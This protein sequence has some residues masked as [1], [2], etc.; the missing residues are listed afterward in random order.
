MPKSQG[1]RN[2]SVTVEIAV[3]AGKSIEVSD[4]LSEYRN[5]E[6]PSVARKRI[7]SY[8][9]SYTPYVPA[10]LSEKEKSKDIL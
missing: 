6:P 9:S 1:F 4:V 10:S 3:P 7:R 5:N 2:Q 8:N